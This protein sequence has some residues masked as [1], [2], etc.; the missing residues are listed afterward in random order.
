MDET[1]IVHR[2][3]QGDLDSFMRGELGIVKALCGIWWRPTRFGPDETKGL[4][5]CEMCFPK[6]RYEL[7]IGA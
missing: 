1:L 6:T 3:Y 7:A 5:R 2:A 4:S